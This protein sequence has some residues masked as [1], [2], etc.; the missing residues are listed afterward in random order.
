MRGKESR[1]ASNP[2]S[3]RTR[4]RVF[5][6]WT[7]RACCSFAATRRTTL[8]PRVPTFTGSI[9]P[10]LGEGGRAAGPATLRAGGNR[11]RW[12]FLWLRG[13]RRRG[14]GEREMIY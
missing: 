11:K 3:H 13:K 8:A 10:P 7:W 4:D 5:A 14:R 6:C 2:T 12:G 9:S 1:D